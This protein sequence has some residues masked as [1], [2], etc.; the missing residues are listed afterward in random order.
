MTWIKKDN[1][2]DSFQ[3]EKIDGNMGPKHGAIEA[4]KETIDDGNKKYE[5]E[6]KTMG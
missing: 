6:I 4:E 3:D 2:K 5:I 1:N